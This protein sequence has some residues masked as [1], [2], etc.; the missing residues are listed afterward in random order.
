MCEKNFTSRKQFK[1]NEGP[2]RVVASLT[3][4]IKH[5]VR[6]VEFNRIGNLAWNDVNIFLAA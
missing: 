3:V 2:H 5:C 1:Y 6:A 4:L